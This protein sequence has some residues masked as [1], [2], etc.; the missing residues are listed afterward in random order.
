MGRWSASAVT[1]IRLAKGVRL[2]THDEWEKGVSADLCYR[3][4]FEMCC[5]RFHDRTGVI[6]D[7]L[8]YREIDALSCDTLVENPH[9]NSV[10]S[11]SI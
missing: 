4:S 10:L 1:A 3:R 6:R 11:I 7:C 8:L 5:P 9:N 2:D